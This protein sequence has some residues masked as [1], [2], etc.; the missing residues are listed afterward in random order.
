MNAHANLWK[1]MPE[2]IAVFR[3]LQLGDM[4]CAV[5]ALRALRKAAPGA[6]ITLVGLP[7]ARDFVHRF[8]HYIDDFL[9]FP[10]FPSMREQTPDVQ[11]LPRFFQDAQQH[12]FD[13]AIQLHGSGTVSNFIV[14]LLGAKRQAGFYGPNIYH[15]ETQHFMP[16]SEQE[17][18]VMR[19]LQLMRFLNVP[20]QGEKLEF[21]LFSE[22]VEA[23]KGIFD[24]YDLEPQRYICLHPGARLPSRRWSAQR[25]GTVAQTL[26]EQGYQ[27]V[28]TGSAAERPLAQKVIHCAQVPVIDLV[29]KTTL[30]ALGAL[31]TASRLLVCNDTGVSHIAAA[32]GTPS[33]VIACGSSVSRW[34]PLDRQ[35]HRVLFHSVECRPC[36]YY[37]C[38][39]GHI[40]A[41][42]VS[43]DAVVHE[44]TTLLQQG[45]RYDS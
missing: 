44:A 6:R 3:A 21:P 20:L 15:P 12:R 19:Y 22:D 11:S 4:L 27:V 10:G 43:V 29:G 13:L 16:W 45:P 41:A 36:E 33:V 40:C 30:G 25:F 34:A 8:S 1:P 42:G 39:V 37:A 28:V 2:R 17:Q 14:T 18:E 5:P 26:T 32:V 9:M 31:V 38:P 24:T 7:W 35:R 23:L